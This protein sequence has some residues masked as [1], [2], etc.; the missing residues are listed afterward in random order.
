MGDYW[1][2]LDHWP[3]ALLAAAIAAIFLLLVDWWVGY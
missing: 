1:Y 2:L 3:V